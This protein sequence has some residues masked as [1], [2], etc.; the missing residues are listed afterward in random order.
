MKKVILTLYLIPYILT[1]MF[2][3]LWINDNSLTYFAG[4]FLL[5]IPV[6]LTLL[7][8]KKNFCFGIRGIIFGNVISFV[9]NIIPV[10]YLSGMN[11]LGGSGIKQY[12]YFGRISVTIFAVLFVL[13]VFL[14]F[15]P[16]K[17]RN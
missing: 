9:C 7:Y 2:L 1:A 12:A 4:L 14:Y 3:L 5:A 11:L 15:R 13:Q 10:L 6:F 8:I 17:H 16:I